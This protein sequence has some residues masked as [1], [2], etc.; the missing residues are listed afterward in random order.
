MGIKFGLDKRTIMDNKN[1]LATGILTPEKLSPPKNDH[2]A[3]HLSI[4]A[5]LNGRILRFNF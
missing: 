4:N 5:T 2:Q 3:Q 1:P